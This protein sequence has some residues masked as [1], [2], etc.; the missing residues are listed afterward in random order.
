[1]ACEGLAP[2]ALLAAAVAA[3]T[4]ASRA[5]STA[6]EATMAEVAPAERGLSAMKS[7]HL[8]LEPRPPPHEKG[9]EPAHSALVRQCHLASF[10]ALWWHCLSLRCETEAWQLA[11]RLQPQ[12]E[13]RLP[14]RPRSADFV[15]RCS[16]IGCR[17]IHQSFCSVTIRV[18]VARPSSPAQPATSKFDLDCEILHAEPGHPRRNRDPCS[19]ADR[20]QGRSL[21]LPLAR[22]RPVI[23]SCRR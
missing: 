21:P 14:G 18:V 23:F 6:E 22:R 13:P 5:C 10:E 12:P 20:L 16:V 7:L 9:S 19:L 8:R 2:G 17:R 15:G 4:S 3:P 1:M 11:W